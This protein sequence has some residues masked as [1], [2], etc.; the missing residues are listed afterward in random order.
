M[1]L[2]TGN[3]R[4]NPSRCNHPK[5]HFPGRLALATA[6]RYNNDAI[7]LRNVLG[8]GYKFSKSQEKI[9]HLM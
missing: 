8:E 9:N 5:N 6:I 1:P 4:P 2:K 3:E 7:Y